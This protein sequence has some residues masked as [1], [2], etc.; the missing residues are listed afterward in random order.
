MTYI[1]KSDL[2]P[3]F[4]F[5]NKHFNTLYRYL[6]NNKNF[7]YK[8]QRFT[9]KDQDFVDLDIATI[10]SKKL[11]L[12]VHGLE[13]NS[14]SGYI[15][16]LVGIAHQY[17]FDVI[18][19]NLR[20]CSGE[21]NKKL[22]SYH[23]GKT[24]DLLEVINYFSSQNKY[25]EMHVVGFSLGGNMTVKLM[26]EIKEVPKILK[27][28]VGVSTPCDLKGSSLVLDKGFNKL[29]QYG[30]LKSL[31]SK[32]KYKLK[33]FP[34][35]GIDTEKLLKCKNFHCFDEHLTSKINNFKNAD[36]YYKKAS[37]KQFIP[38]I[39]IPTL[40]I[41]A[42]DDSFLSESCYP[43]QEVKTNPMVDLLTPTYGGHVGFY[44][45]FKGVKNYWLEEQIMAFVKANS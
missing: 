24:D 11:I 15:K 33:Q 23:S 16:S 30:I 3:N 38:S 43:Y 28:A 17:G 19:L 10:N 29:Y 44:A 6:I 40:I 20:G 12:A 34:K 35:S 7:Q 31:L 32:A 5:R 41:N 22:S 13:G 2:Q 36:D 4:F 18:A 8:R 25:Q 27:S 39:K 26:G 1:P 45:S 9:T 42:L 37:C 14:Q 21:P